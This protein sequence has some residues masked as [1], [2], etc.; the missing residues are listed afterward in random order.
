[1]TNKLLLIPQNALSDHNIL[2]LNKELSFSKDTYRVI[3]LNVAQRGQMSLFPTNDNFND[4]YFSPTFRQEK[5]MKEAMT[6][7]KLIKI[8]NGINELHKLLFD[9]F[10]QIIIDNSQNNKEKLNIFNTCIDIFNKNFK[11]IMQTL[12]EFELVD[13]DSEYHKKLMEKLKCQYDFYNQNF[14]NITPIK[15]YAYKL[16]SEID[17]IN[18]MKRIS[19]QLYGA[20]DFICLQEVEISK[21]NL[22]TLLVLGYW[23][24]SK[25]PSNGNLSTAYS[26]ESMAIIF[27]DYNKY[28]PIDLLKDNV[29]IHKIIIEGLFKLLN[30]I[31]VNSAPTD[32]NYKLNIVCFNDKITPKYV[33]VVNVHADWA[34]VNK[35]IVLLFSIISKLFKIFKDKLIIAGDFNIVKKNYEKEIDE[36]LFPHI[37]IEKILTPELRTNIQEE[38]DRTY[39]FIFTGKEAL[40]HVLNYEKILDNLNKIC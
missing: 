22:S 20:V 19:N 8:K 25:F 12:T 2:F 38:E 33:Y 3:Q 30:P 32:N 27:Y 36:T 7:P 5:T 24:A 31:T 40:G 39:D 15:K 14:D 26:L 16:E 28:E 1:M 4:F 10:D 13:E 34:I 21:D 23:N 37:R 9:S 11:K 6:N 35:Y 29:H 17:F 18:R